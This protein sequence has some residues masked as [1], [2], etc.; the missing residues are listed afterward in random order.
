VKK[1]QFKILESRCSKCARINCTCLA[2]Q[3]EVEVDCQAEALPNENF[4]EIHLEESRQ[5]IQSGALSDL[6][7][8]ISKVGLRSILKCPCPNWIHSRKKKKEEIEGLFE[9]QYVKKYRDPFGDYRCVLEILLFNGF[10]DRFTREYELDPL[11][12]RLALERLIISIVRVSRLES[13]IAHMG[14]KVFVPV[15]SNGKLIYEI[16]EH[17]FNSVISNLDARMERWL[18]ALKLSRRQ[19][20]PNRVEVEIDWSNILSNEELE[21][22]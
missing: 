10:W 11:A 8:P 14:E 1:C 21:E 6:H 16:R 2:P 7:S 5:L 18:N 4:C 19:R 17:Y 22:E 9:C 12:D 20:E 15:Y 3:V 13:E